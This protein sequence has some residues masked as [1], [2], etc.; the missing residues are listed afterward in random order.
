MENIIDL[1]KKT[2]LPNVKLDNIKEKTT[3]LTKL[4]ENLNTF[5]NKVA[6]LLIKNYLSNDNY[7]ALQLLDKEKC[8]NVSLYLKDNIFSILSEIEI[9]GETFVYDELNDKQ[10]KQKYIYCDRIVFKFIRIFNVIATLLINMNPENNF[11]IDRLN[12]LYESINDEQFKTNICK[13]Q[14]ITFLE[15]KG[16][17]ELIN[18]FMYDLIVYNDMNKTELTKEYNN[19]LD[20][21]AEILSSKDLKRFNLN[22]LNLKAIETV[23]KLHHKKLLNNTETNKMSQQNNT[24]LNNS[25]TENKSSEEYN[26]QITNLQNELQSLQESLK[27]KNE[28]SNRLNMEINNLTQKL[29]AL[30][31]DYS[32][33]TNN[34]SQIKEEYSQL[35][36]GY[37][38]IREELII[39]R[40]KEL[41]KLTNE[42]ENLISNSDKLAAKQFGGMEQSINNFKEFLAKYSVNEPKINKIVSLMD[43]TLKMNN[44]P[45]R[46]FCSAA[47]KSSK[48]SKQDN[49]SF[50]INY[51]LESSNMNEFFRIYNK[52]VEYYDSQIKQMRD[53]LNRIIN[54]NENNKESENKQ[55]ESITVKLINVNNDELRDIEK[56]CRSLIS[57]YI[58]SVQQ[59]YL[60]AIESLTEYLN[61]E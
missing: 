2:F 46:T 33:L 49:A 44:I 21:F 57:N 24:S 26:L 25:M 3:T 50:I 56:E 54:I 40:N 12:I 58:V 5:S 53:L 23:F 17:M 52:L 32:L 59:S 41:Q 8:K 30:E 55:T 22:K 47:E 36:D 38:Q 4:N 11:A 15:E 48:V 43:T 34:H 28:N 14:Q 16:V 29:S 45:T 20:L 27:L 19:M 18:M 60:K 42:V 31:N 1:F 9:K 13:T 35:K 37:S 51:N 7:L 39:E 6:E 10:M 61:E